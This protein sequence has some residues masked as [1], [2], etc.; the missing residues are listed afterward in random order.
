MTKVTESHVDHII[1][2]CLLRTDYCDY[3]RDWSEHL[4]KKV[5]SHH[6]TRIGGIEESYME[7][8]NSE[9]DIDLDESVREEMAED[10]LS[11]RK[12]FLFKFLEKKISQLKIQLS[13]ETRTNK[14]EDK[15]KK[16]V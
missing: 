4:R 5:R 13:L 12:K 8:D 10:T 11:K 16:R 7:S 2:V 9:E 6:S 1:K 14:D 3:V 15:T